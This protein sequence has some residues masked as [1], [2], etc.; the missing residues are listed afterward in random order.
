MCDLTLYRECDMGCI[1][2]SNYFIDEYLA[3][4]NDAQ[5]KV[6]LYLVRM[7]GAGR[8]TNISDIADKFNHTEKDVCRALRYW[9]KKGIISL[10]YDKNGGIVGIRLYEPA[11]RPRTISPMASVV[12]PMPVKEVAPAPAPAPQTSTL[13]ETPAKPAYTSSDL[14]AFRD[15]E[16]TPQLIFVAEQYLKK[17]LTVADI[18]S[19]MYYSDE[20]N[21]SFDLIDYLLQYCTGRGKTSFRYMDTVA[22]DWAENAITSVKQ[23]KAYTSQFEPAAPKSNIRSYST[24]KKQT[25]LHDMEQIDYDFAD[26][27]RLKLGQQ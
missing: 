17:N 1:S 27:E 14:K 3:D 20:L 21:F 12:A 6:Y 16:D 11:T 2:V 26:I 7:T 18:K 25:S 5:I 19:I 4:A 22:V 9:E 10:D 8:P 13:A 24:P 23:A 15:R